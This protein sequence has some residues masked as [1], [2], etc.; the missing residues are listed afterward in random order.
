MVNVLQKEVVSH[1][2]PRTNMVTMNSD[3]A[4]VKRKPDLSHSMV[5]SPINEDITNLQQPYICDGSYNLFLYKK[6]SSPVYSY[7]QWCGK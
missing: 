6:V 2:F 7:H 1:L 3:K 5:I 4:A